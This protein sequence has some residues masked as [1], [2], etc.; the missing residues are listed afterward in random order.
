MCSIEVRRHRAHELSVY[1]AT[2]TK[3]SKLLFLIAVAAVAQPTFPPAGMRCPERTLVV[4]DFVK[5]NADVIS[6]FIGMRFDYE[7]IESLAELSPGDAMLADWEDK[8]VA[9]YKDDNGKVHALDPVCPHA[10][11]LVAWNNAEKSWDCPCHGSRFACNG[12]LLTGP[13]RRGLTNILGED[14]EGD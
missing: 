11:C 9:L 13:A 10:K 3:M 12:S 5:E 2:I 8:K 6:K 1:R 14:I 4:F 7:K